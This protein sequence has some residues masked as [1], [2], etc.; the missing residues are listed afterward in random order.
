MHE[1][2]LDESAQIDNLEISVATTMA[3]S[4]QKVKMMWFVPEME[5]SE[6]PMW[7]ASRERIAWNNRSSCWEYTIGTIADT[8]TDY[9]ITSN[10]NPKRVYIWICAFCNN[11]HRVADDKKRG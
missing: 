3:L 8:L 7:I 10:L 5:P 9:Y 2:G 4:E 11:Q 1:Y 6:L